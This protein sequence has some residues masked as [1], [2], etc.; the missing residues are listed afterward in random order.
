M[1]LHQQ[2]LKIQLPRCL[3][4]T[5]DVCQHISGLMYRK[6]TSRLSLSV[7]KITGVCCIYSTCE[8]LQHVG[9]SLLLAEASA[10]SHM[11]NPQSPA[12]NSCLC[13]ALP[14]AQQRLAVD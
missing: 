6:N 4:C 14:L 7:S 10:E 11:G 9:E 3:G 12:A 13:P 5:A 1:R 8:K 2:Q